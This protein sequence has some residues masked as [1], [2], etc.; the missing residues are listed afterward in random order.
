[1]SE[2]EKRDGLENNGNATVSRCIYDALWQAHQNIQ[3]ALM[4]AGCPQGAEMAEWIDGRAQIHRAQV[5]ALS[6][7][8]EY[9][10]DLEALLRR[11]GW[12]EGEMK[13][14]WLQVRLAKLE[15]L[16]RKESA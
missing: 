14:H 2:F 10:D 1:M 12:A 16:E 8:N 5:V 7:W 11:Y 4:R 13:M 15:D 6:T 3:N 9:N